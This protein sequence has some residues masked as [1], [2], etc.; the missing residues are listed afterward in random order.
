VKVL[1]DSWKGHM[2]TSGKPDDEPLVMP[3]LFSKQFRETSPD[4][5]RDIKA[6][7]ARGYLSRNSEAFDRQL[8]ANV[9]HN[10]KG[11]LKTIGVP[12]LILVGMDDA[13]TPPRL[14]EDLHAE[15]PHSKLVVFECGG[16]G[17]YW[18]IPH[19]FNQT[20]LDFLTSQD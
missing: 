15:I 11:R 17:L 20:V 12:T 2:A 10:L 6:R 13:L 19:L 8:K 7:F 18:E 5:I 16:H 1:Y 4:R 9:Q 14:A 3:W